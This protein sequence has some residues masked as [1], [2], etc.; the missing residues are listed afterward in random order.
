M[1]KHSNNSLEKKWLTVSYQPVSL[2][3]LK[4]SDATSMAA[5]SN[6]VPTPYAI[7]MALLKALL[8]SQ[9]KYHQD[10]FGAWIKEEFAWIRDLLIYILPPEQLVVNRNGY[11]LR[12][13]DQTADKADKSRSTIPMQDGF[14]FRE[15][16]HLQGELQI[17]CGDGLNKLQEL[18]NLFAQINYFGKKGCFF[19]YLPDCTQVTNEPTFIPNP[20]ASFTI[21]PMD[22]LGEKTTFNRI[23]PFS[24][25][26]AQID[27]DRIITPGFLP[28]KLHSTSTRYDF[29][30]RD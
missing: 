9:G 28:L 27:K 10:D 8:E 17:C 15:W 19:Q 24:N 21:Q 7:K 20:N 3:T 14:V 11:K 4:R 29:Y 6:L 30:Q 12:Y 18:T 13:Y 1:P 26:K 5:R 22:D 25:D 23:N 2:F 16:I